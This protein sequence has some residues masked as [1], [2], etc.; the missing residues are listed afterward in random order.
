[1]FLK[2]NIVIKYDNGGKQTKK[3]LIVVSICA[4]VLLVLGS[5]N[6]VVGYQTVQ[7]SN[8]KI[9]N[10]CD[11]VDIEI[12]AGAYENTNGNYG[13]CFLISITNN[14][15]QYITVNMTIYWNITNDK[16]V[17]R[18]IQLV[19]LSPHHPEIQFARIDYIHFPFPV[20]KLK[21]IV[22]VNETSTSVS[23]SGIEIGPFVFFSRLESFSCSE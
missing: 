7:S 18:E 3:P 9:K 11:D 10:T 21:V 8:Q 12:R 5:L 1:M 15:D 19:N 20:I 17:R 6:N 23:R 13:L 2:E 4:V 22:K 14:L 16:T